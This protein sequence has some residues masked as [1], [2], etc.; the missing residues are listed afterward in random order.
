MVNNI[1]KTGK[2]QFTMQATGDDGFEFFDLKLKM[3]T[4]K[5][6]VDVFFKTD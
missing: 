6:N 3:V 2:V 4:G 5:I 1:D